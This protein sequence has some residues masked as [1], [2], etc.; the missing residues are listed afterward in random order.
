[1]EFF[2]PHPLRKGTCSEKDARNQ[3]KPGGNSRKR[4][5][6]SMEKGVAFL[7]EILNRPRPLLPQLNDVPYGF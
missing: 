5:H 7:G 1:M 6:Y 2:D 4:H 3:V